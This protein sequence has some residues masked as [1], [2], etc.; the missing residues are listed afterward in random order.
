MKKILFFVI[1][2]ILISS[3]FFL[4]KSPYTLTKKTPFTNIRWQE[5][6]AFVEI[7]GQTYQWL[8]SEE[9][10]LEKIIL[11]AKKKYRDRW[12][13]RIST[14]YI[15][16]LRDMGHWT[17]FSTHIKL[18]DSIG[19]IV[20]KRISLSKKNRETTKHNLYKKKKIK[21]IHNKIT[22]DSLK[23]I[24]QRI[25]GYQPF[26][27]APKA[28]MEMFEHN[29]TLPMDSWISTPLA[30]DDLEHLEYEIQNH[31]SYAELKG[32]NYPMVI[33]VIISDLKT[34]ISKRDLAIQVKRLMAL[35]GDGHSRISR[36]KLNI[37]SLF[38]PFTIKKIE[39]KYIALSKNKLY[40]ISYPE[41]ISID[42]YSIDSLKEK[43][44]E[45]VSKGSP[46]FYERTCL[47]YL[48]YYGFLKTQLKLNEKLINLQLSNGKDT[49]TKKSQ[50]INRHEFKK[51]IKSNKSH[52]K[53]LNNNIGYI[54]LH[55]MSKTSDY[56]NW[57]QTTMD[58]FKNTNGLIIDIRGNG[59]GNRKP[60]YTLLPYFIKS[61]K[62]ININT[63]RINK[64]IDPDVNESIGDL[65]KR[66]AYPEKSKH[67][68]TEERKAIKYF[69]QDFVAEWNFDR[70]KFSKWHYSVVSPNKDY[71]NKQVII[72]MDED[73]FSAS[74]IFLAA[75]KGTKNITLIGSK[76]G[77]GSG[78]AQ[79]KFLANS[80]IMYFLSRMASFQPNGRLYDG[81]GISPDKEIKETLYDLINEKDVVMETAIKTITK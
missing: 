5:E 39:G 45:M 25:D 48:S 14:D 4:Y 75:F 31:Y 59:G 44:G 69:K 51:N 2:L 40:N 41:I 10:R 19:Q 17:F 21:R 79:I 29:Y 35:F 76:S 73:N 8:A 20:D 23:Y 24:T 37:D 56:Q 38:L 58:E 36:A 30:I 26:E 62:V 11:F 32:I 67:W 61:P 68:T 54:Y 81:N 80:G 63:F 74:D 42:G 43:A 50:L 7:N 27:N 18:K 64:N 70:S 72:L 57:L 47:T 77:G 22:S 6:K 3:A 52:H 16:V 15:L 60:I 1:A 46:Q 78:F 66:M 33:D 71:Y 13:N 9:E 12:Q 34:G 49:I 53:L 55:K 65:D 28:E